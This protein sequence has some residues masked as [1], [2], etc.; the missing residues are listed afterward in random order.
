MQTVQTKKSSVKN[1]SL[2]SGPAGEIPDV[3]TQKSFVANSLQKP[4]IKGDIW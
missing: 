1:Q 4:L 2:Q 3:Q